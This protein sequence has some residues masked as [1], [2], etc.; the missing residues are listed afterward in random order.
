M[1]KRFRPRAVLW[2]AILAIGGLSGCWSAALSPRSTNACADCA[3]SSSWYSWC[4]YNQTYDDIVTGFSARR[5]ASAALADLRRSCQMSFSQDYQRGFTQAFIDTANGRRTGVPAVAPSRYWQAYYRTPAG[6]LAVEDW[7]N[8]YGQGLEA[9]MQSCLP[10]SNQIWVRGGDCATYCQLSQQPGYSQ[11]TPWAQRTKPGCQRHRGGRC[12]AGCR[13]DVTIGQTDGT[14]QN[15]AADSAASPASLTQNSFVPAAARLDALFTADAADRGE[16]PANS[17]AGRGAPAT[18]IAQPAV[19]SNGPYAGPAIPGSAGAVVPG[20]YSGTAP[21]EQLSSVADW[22]P[23]P[24]RATVPSRSAYQPAEPRSSA[25]RSIRGELND[26]PSRSG[27]LRPLANDRDSQSA[28]R[29]REIPESSVA[30]LPTRYPQEASP[31]GPWQNALSDQA[32][33]RPTGSPPTYESRT[34]P[35]DIPESS[36]GPARSRGGFKPADWDR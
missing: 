21:G 9:A 15:P 16:P 22:A 5:L 25:S 13:G 34:V 6:Q 17:P 1:N 27:P 7:F 30:P 8:G 19:M 24:Q 23:V 36:N 4:R 14:P 10:S 3:P 31:G 32:H 2:V 11:L 20:F 35:R 18:F 12:P 28:A 29:P 33:G 26:T